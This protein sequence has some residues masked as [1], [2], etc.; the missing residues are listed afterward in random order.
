MAWKRLKSPGPVRAARAWSR[1]HA[2]TKTFAAID[3]IVRNR[4]SR[5]KPARK[6]PPCVNQSFA[7]LVHARKSGHQ[8]VYLAGCT[9]VVGVYALL[10]ARDAMFGAARRVSTTTI[11][12]PASMRRSSNSEFRFAS[13]TALAT[14]VSDAFLQ[15]TPSEPPPKRYSS[16]PTIIR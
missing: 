3:K 16:L 12:A 13:D 10:V 4:L 8:H 14:R 5:G 1:A 11:I 2:L 9:A 7:T 15:F 6:S